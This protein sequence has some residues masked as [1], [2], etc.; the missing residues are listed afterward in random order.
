MPKRKTKPTPVGRGPVT[1]ADR[2]W[3]T[4][5][6]A[7]LRD[8]RLALGLTQRQLAERVGVSDALIGHYETGITKPSFEALVRLAE[9]LGVSAVVLAPGLK[10]M[11]WTD[12]VSEEEI[13][14]LELIR[15]A[16]KP[17]RNIAREIMLAMAADATAGRKPKP[18]P[19]LT[20]PRQ[21]P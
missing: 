20:R 12:E 2:V 17:N 6:P 19:R 10:G 14:I 9:A 16:S 18:A 13:Y 7:R 21:A 15:R 11:R 4:K 3:G 8:R 5:F 1:L